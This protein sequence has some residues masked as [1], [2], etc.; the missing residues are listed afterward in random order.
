MND[1]VDVNDGLPKRYQTVHFADNKRAYYGWWSGEDWLAMKD[2][3]PCYQFT[4]SKS[5]ITHWMPFPNSPNE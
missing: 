3:E 5:D 1:W 2:G 4:E